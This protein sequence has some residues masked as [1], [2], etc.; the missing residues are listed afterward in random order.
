M[1]LLLL[2]WFIIV[3]L[4]DL[5]HARQ[6]LNATPI[7]PSLKPLL[8]VAVSLE[9]DLKIIFLPCLQVR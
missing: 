6:L 8:L 7:D 5:H 9:N 1:C 2:Y 3:A 4:I